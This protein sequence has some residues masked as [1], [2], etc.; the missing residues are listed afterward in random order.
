M[1]K[2]I[3]NIIFLIIVISLIFPNNKKTVKIEYN[4]AEALVQLSNLGI[5]LDHYRTTNLIHAYATDEEIKLLN[6]IGYQVTEIPNYSY[7]YFIS[8]HLVQFEIN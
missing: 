8:H 5:E 4:S 7:L 3:L 6:S 1:K 2:K